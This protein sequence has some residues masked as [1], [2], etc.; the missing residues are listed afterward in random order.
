MSSWDYRYVL[1]YPDYKG[2][3]IKENYRPISL[4]HIH[5]KKSSKITNL[6]QKCIKIV[7]NSS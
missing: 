2:I 5:E 4:R 6:I 7:N 1:V 3:L